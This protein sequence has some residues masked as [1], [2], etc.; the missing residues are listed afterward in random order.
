MKLERLNGDFVEPLVAGT[1]ESRQSSVRQLASAGEIKEKSSEIKAKLDAVLSLCKRTAERIQ[2]RLDAEKD[3]YS[4]CYQEQFSAIARL[5]A[6]AS[7]E[8]SNAEN[9]SIESRSMAKE[10]CLDHLKKIQKLISL[11]TELQLSDQKLLDMAILWQ[12]QFSKKS[13]TIQELSEDLPNLAS[14]AN[15]A[16]SSFV[17]SMAS[18]ESCEKRSLSECD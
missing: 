5:E 9:L 8:A 12:D 10:E 7:D 1:R 4:T 15:Q 3:R 13:I 17:S 11:R 16:A 2:G 6:E 14:K 18:F